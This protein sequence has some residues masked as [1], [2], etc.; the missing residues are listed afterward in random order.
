MKKAPLTS[1]AL[2][3]L[4]FGLAACDN[5]DAEG[6]G[7]APQE[8][9]QEDVQQEGPEGQQEM[10]EPDLGDLPDVVATVND[11]DIEAEEYE[12][13]Y[14]NQFMNAQMMSQMTGEQPDEDELQEQTLEQVIG[15]RLLIHD[16]EEQGFDASEEEVEEELEATAEENGLESLDQLFEMAEEQGISEDELR[17]QAEDQV[18]VEKLID[19]FDVDEPTEEELEESYEEQ[20]AQQPEAEEGADGEE[21]PE[22]PEF[23]EVR[24]EIH[25]QM[26]QQRQNEAAQEHVDQLREDADV[27]THI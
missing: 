26:M 23:D 22:T 5:G 15:N 16:A 8:Q 17:G 11:E 21:A 27:E 6:D 14:Q 12:A 24:D 20:V 25:E 9:A 19:S 7:E 3:G 13:A 1:L 18:R 10:S 4:L 2:A